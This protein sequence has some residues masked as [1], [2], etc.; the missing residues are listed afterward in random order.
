[1]II[2]GGSCA[3]VVSLSIIEKLNLQTSTHPHPYNIQWLKQSKG[4]QVSLRCLVSFSIGK[5]YH[6]ELW[7]DIIPMDAYHMLLGRPWLFDRKVTHN[8]Y[9]NT[10]SFTKDGKKVTLASL[11]PSQL[12]NAK[13]QKNQDYSDLLLAYSE[14]ILKA[15]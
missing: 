12:Q 2:D 10:Y 3:N 9:L 7:F 11:T 14:L 1:L 15:S 13:P 8:G 5:N 6:D 4:L